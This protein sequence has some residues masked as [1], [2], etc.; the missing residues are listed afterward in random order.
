MSHTHTLRTLPGEQPRRAATGAC[1]AGDQ[2]RELAAL[3]KGLDACQQAVTVPSHDQSPVVEQRTG[4]GQ[5]ERHVRL[6]LGVDVVPQS[7]RLLLEGT[8]VPGGQNP[9]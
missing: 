6:V 4:R 8:G 5:R 7:S 3:G 2:P 9:R 1:L